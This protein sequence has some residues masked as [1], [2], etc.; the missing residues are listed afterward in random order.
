[1]PHCT[2]LLS[3]KLLTHQEGS[4]AS[5]KCHFRVRHFGRVFDFTVVKEALAVAYSL[6]VSEQ[7]CLLASHA[8]KHGRSLSL[9]TTTTSSFSLEP[10]CAR[11]TCTASTTPPVLHVAL[12]CADM[13]VPLNCFT[14]VACLLTVLCFRALAW[15]PGRICKGHSCVRAFDRVFVLP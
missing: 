11:Y 4:A 1:M 12:S 14:L 7:P 3:L 5:H 6:F 13:H 10:Q 9:A 15:R 8:S 2:G